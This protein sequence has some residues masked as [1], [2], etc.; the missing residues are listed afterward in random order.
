[1]CCIECESYTGDAKLKSASSGVGANSLVNHFI[2]R[3]LASQNLAHAFGINEYKTLMTINK[4][5]ITAIEIPKYVVNTV[6]NMISHLKST[7]TTKLAPNKTKPY[8]TYDIGSCTD[9]N[10]VNY[11]LD[12]RAISDHL[13]HSKQRD[14][15]GFVDTV[16][17]ELINN[18]KSFVHVFGIPK[19]DT[20]GY[21][22][23]IRDVVDAL[24][25]MVAYFLA[26]SQNGQASQVN[27]LLISKWS[28]TKT[29]TSMHLYRCEIR[30]G[31]K[32]SI[33]ALTSTL[34]NC[35]NN[36]GPT[37]HRS[38]TSPLM[39]DVDLNID[40]T[41]KMT[42]PKPKAEDSKIPMVGFIHDDL[43]AHIN[44]TI[45]PN[46][47]FLNLQHVPILYID[48]LYLHDRVELFDAH[49]PQS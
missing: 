2:T 26:G 20:V 3:P 12:I 16:H 25:H 44:N 17:D 46:V 40:L 32:H 18:E 4:Q 43:N 38:P 24:E 23:S 10:I 13:A 36:T 28:P 33:T 49:V 19:C 22:D 1:M 14:I 6:L 30:N 45:L 8:K 5:H 9:I 37:G 48:L 41:S 11:L 31:F 47:Y 35:N 42:E 21:D 39:E 34:N 7:M 27:Y 15:K 29:T